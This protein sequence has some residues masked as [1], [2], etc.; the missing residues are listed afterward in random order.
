VV[1]FSLRKYFPIQ[2]QTNKQTGNAVR[3]TI[4]L[5]SRE[6]ETSRTLKAQHDTQKP[7]Y[8]RENQY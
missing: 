2:K 5:G 3:K 8:F 6:H 1:E 4:I 7:D